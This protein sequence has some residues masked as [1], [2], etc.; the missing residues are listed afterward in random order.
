[1][2]SRLDT[3]LIA[4][5]EE[6]T[7]LRTSHRVLLQSRDESASYILALRDRVFALEAALANVVA[8]REEAHRDT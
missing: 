6:I 8:P 4:L 1:M 5:N 2:T 3:A 7:T